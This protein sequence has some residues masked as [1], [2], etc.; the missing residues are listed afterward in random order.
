VL[1][2]FQHLLFRVGGGLRAA[3]RL[4]GTCFSLVELPFARVGIDLPAIGERLTLIGQVFALVGKP[5]AVVRVPV[6]PIFRLVSLVCGILPLVLRYGPLTPVVGLR[7]VV[8]SHPTI[9]RLHA[10]ACRGC[11]GD[12]CKS[13]APSVHP[14][15]VLG[16]ANV[17]ANIEAGLVV[18]DCLDGDVIR[19]RIRPLPWEAPVEQHHG[20]LTARLEHLNNQIRRHRG[21]TGDA[22]SLT[23]SGRLQ[24]ERSRVLIGLSR[25]R[26]EQ[27]KALH[28][29]A[30]QR[31]GRQRG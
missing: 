8:G 14:S 23:I 26:I 3:P 30:A 5:F 22:A 31:L 2:G 28:R 24:A 11:A 25:W 4:V 18:V 15:A 19:P 6:S 13:T 29:T 27:A 10:E 17:E 21:Q 7:Q 20:E 16:F 9:M 1:D 12:R